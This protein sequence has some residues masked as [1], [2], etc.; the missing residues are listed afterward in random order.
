MTIRATLRNNTVLLTA[1]NESRAELADLLRRDNGFN[2]AAQY[3]GEQLHEDWEF[4]A[5]EDVGALTDSPIL[6]ECDGLDRDD[7]GE[8]TA[9][10]K[11]C[12]FPDYMVRDPWEELR[13]R[14][15]TVFSLAPEDC[16]A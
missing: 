15:R 14:G 13:N 8:L 1:D 9:V 10:G 12:W 2:R 6:A 5:P 7:H 3:V 4:V 11:V 16:A